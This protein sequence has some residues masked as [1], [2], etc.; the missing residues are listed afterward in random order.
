[1][2]QATVKEYYEDLFGTPTALKF[3]DVANMYGMDYLLINH[4]DEKEKIFEKGD[5][6]LRLIEIRTNRNENVQAHRKL[7][8]HINSELKEWLL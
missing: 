8:Q 2:S 7:W 1:M 4:F 6:P 5:K 3:Q